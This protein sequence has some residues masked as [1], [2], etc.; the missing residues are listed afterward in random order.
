MPYYILL[1]ILFFGVIILVHELGHFAFAKLFKV[2]INEFSVGFGP[3]LF[4]KKGKDGVIY[5]LRA[6]P[7]GGYVS[8]VGEDEKVDDEN[9]FSS[10]PVWQR[11]IITAAGAA[12]NIIL[13]IILTGILVGSA[14]RIYSTT[15]SGFN[16]VSE[17]G[18]KLEFEEFLGIRVGDTIKKIGNRKINVR[19]DFVYEIMFRGDEGVDVTVERDGKDVLIKDVKFGTFS[20]DGIVFGNAAFIRT[21]ELEK[22]FPEFIKQTFCQ[23]FSSI[24]VLWSS[25][26]NIF[27]GRYGVETLS[28]PVGVIGQVKETASYGWESLVFLLTMLTLNVGIINLL[29]LP[30]FD[31]GRLFFMLIELIRGKP[32]DPKY[33]G[34]VHAAGFV[35]IMIFM[36]FITYNDIAKLIFR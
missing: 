15:V 24:R 33:E 21:T 35:L 13:G 6:I 9:A 5:S 36:I 26:L 30:A 31:G 4:S 1:G 22:T 12:M 23:A 2:G 25:I 16:V 20:E 28:G 18:E 11:I 7:I 27:K 8:M 34:Y 19:N 3:K 17:S 32:V 10:K 14:E 29:P